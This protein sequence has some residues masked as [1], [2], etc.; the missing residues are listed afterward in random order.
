MVSLAIGVYLGVSA[1]LNWSDDGHRWAAYLIALPIT[2]ALGWQLIT[3]A[4]GHRR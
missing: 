2:A 4:R 3:T 1:F